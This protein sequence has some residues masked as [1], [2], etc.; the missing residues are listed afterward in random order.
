VGFADERNLTERALTAYEN[1]EP[2]DL[3]LPPV[4]DRILRAREALGLTQADVAERWG[5]QVSM[6]WD[7]ELFDEEA[8]TVI[9]VVEFQRLAAVLGTSVSRLLF[10]E[11][12]PPPW[13]VISYSDVV[14]RLRARMAE[15]A[16]SIEEM[17]DRVGWELDSIMSDREALGDLPISALR[18]ICLTAGVDW[19]SVL[20]TPIGQT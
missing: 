17:A 8:L 4:A 5:Q 20:V 18:S 14:A 2:I 7:L 12:P 1:D 11:E 10:G 19:F 16:L 6:Y 15:D 9:S 13:P 3:V